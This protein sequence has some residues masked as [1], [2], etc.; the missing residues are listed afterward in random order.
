[1]KSRK[2]TLLVAV[3]MVLAA[4]LLAW[5][6]SK[7]HWRDYVM[8]DAGKTHA[9]IRPVQA[10]P[11]SEGP[12]AYVVSTGM[13]WWQGEKKIAC[14][15]L[16]SA[17]DKAK[18]PNYVRD[19][20][21]S[22]I[23]GINR[24]LL[25]LAVAGFLF[26]FLASAL[27]WWI[28]LHIQDIWVGLWEVV[29]L[30]FLGLFFNFIVPGTVGGDLVKAYY[31]SKHTPH[32]AAVLVSVF[33]DRL[34]GFAQLS[35]LAATMT[36]VALLAGMRSPD[37]LAHPI[38]AI[39]IVLA[40]LALM[41]TFLLSTRFRQALHLQ[42]VYRRLPIAH[43]IAAAGD[44]MGLYS[45]RMGRLGKAIAITAL[46]H[47]VFVGA[48][49]LIGRSLSLDVPLYNYYIFVPL[50]YIAGAVPITPGG[51]G[52]IEGLYVAM[53]VSETC[54]S[55]QVLALALLARAIP[56]FWAL[57]GAVVAVTGTKIPQADV[58]EAE[59]GIDD[60]GQT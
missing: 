1:M 43:H 37:Q 28:L 60:Q 39:P 10:D 16:R 30:T 44:A 34:L 59:L 8:T 27:R 2:K 17:D 57:P 52:V 51:V 41:L 3:K 42:K 13:L 14:D 20:F 23:V 6:L 21:A 53:F 19:G 45:R 40:V 48:I 38:V 35:L 18:R 33:V 36:A 55:S 32:K 31:V 49:A 25:G 29:R 26:C 4:L 9:V 46:A 47:V 54:T 11:P 24:L 5:V 58:L 22:V 56:M 12:K 7:T 50:I 15:E